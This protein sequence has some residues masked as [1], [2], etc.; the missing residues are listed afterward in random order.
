MN[1][2]TIPKYKS[3][4]EFY[5]EEMTETAIYINEFARLIRQYDPEVHL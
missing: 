5:T 4:I 1:D 3:T 2:D